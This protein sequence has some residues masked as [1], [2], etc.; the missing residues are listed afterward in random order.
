MKKLFKEF[1]AF[2][3]RGN[4]ID[5]AVAV[6]IGAA[7]SAIVTSLVNDI[8]M[9][10][11]VRIFPVQDLSSLSL[12]LRPE[13][14]PGAGD[15]LT[16]NY[17][18]FIQALINFLLI[19]V[20]IFAMLKVV[21]SAKGALNPKHCKTLTKDEYKALKRAGKTKAEIR[22]ID[23]QKT[24]EKSEIEARAK[25]EA[26]AN[27]TAALLKRVVELLEKIESHKEEK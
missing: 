6:I 27:T 2:I 8:I 22:Q 21:M 13:S 12:I 19:A 10:L 9:P 16:W 15:A 17:G 25:A 11:I 3:S 20:V 24:I 14:A 26:D 23:E 1:K 18:N 5:L 4:I 7:F